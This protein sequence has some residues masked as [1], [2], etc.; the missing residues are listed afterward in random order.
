MNRVVPIGNTGDWLIRC[1]RDDVARL[2][3]N[4]NIWHD[5][6]MDDDNKE[7]PEWFVIT[8]GKPKP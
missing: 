5:G 7:G 6:P 8:E 1:H 3:V 2:K 4:N